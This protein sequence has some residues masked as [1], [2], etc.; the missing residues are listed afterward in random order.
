[1]L[2]SS[3][4]YISFLLLIF[5][6]PSLLTHLSPSPEVFDNPHQAAHYHTVDI[7]VVGFNSDSAFGWL[8]S[9][10]VKISLRFDF[11]IILIYT[12]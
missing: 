7:K 12:K 10:G 5:I 6:R 2:R 8:Q 1:M 3:S 11:N 9:E 4:I